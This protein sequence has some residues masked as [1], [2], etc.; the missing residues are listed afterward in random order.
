MIWILGLSVLLYALVVAVFFFGQRRLIYQPHRQTEVPGAWGAGALSTVLC[1]TEDGLE[2]A[3]WYRAPPH[4]PQGTGGALVVLFHGNA[5]HLGL[6]ADK[7]RAMLEAG[8]GVLLAGYRGY[9][10]NPGTPSEQGLL[11]DGRAWL[12]F[13]TREG[14]S[15]SRLVLWGESLGGGIA[16]RLATERRVRAVILEAAF[17]SLTDVAASLYPWLP[18]RS[19][20]LDRY[21]SLPRIGELRAPLLIVHGE[22]DR[23]VPVKFGRALFDAAAEPKQAYWAEEGGHN[24]LSRYG[25][26]E[27]AVDFLGRL[28]RSETVPPVTIEQ[29][30]AKG[31]AVVKQ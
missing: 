25:L 3:G 24:D 26:L 15:G 21:D 10:G 4:E 29:A 31:T 12:D 2:L 17:T 14:V 22:R 5:G 1:R 9:G 6:R 30:V 27:A 23:I 20:L 8:H 16:V 18:V 13:L 19:M 7:A 28:R 11:T